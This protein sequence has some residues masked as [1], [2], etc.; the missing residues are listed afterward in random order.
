MVDKLKD[1]K[2]VME[3][4]NQRLLP[5]IEKVTAINKMVIKVIEAYKEDLHKYKND[6]GIVVE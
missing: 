3:Y 4:T 2:Y 1:A 5:M 6:V